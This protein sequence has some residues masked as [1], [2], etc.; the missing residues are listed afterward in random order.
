MPAFDFLLRLDELISDLDLFLAPE[1]PASL[2]LVPPLPVS[3]TSADL[4]ACCGSDET[5]WLYT[6]ML[7]LQKENGP[8]AEFCW[9]RL[10]VIAPER[11]SNSVDFFTN[12][13]LALLLQRRYQEALRLLERAVEKAPD[14]LEIRRRLIMALEQAKRPPAE[15]LSQVQAALA[16]A[17]NDEEL[18]E[19]QSQLEFELES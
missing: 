4:E 19:K 13:G 10:S 15:I 1:G 12:L 3:Y 17:P 7:L 16:L 2:R 11:W 5:R 6:A 14:R 8:L 9:R 18:Q